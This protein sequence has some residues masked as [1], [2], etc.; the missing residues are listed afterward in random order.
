MSK[1]TPKEIIRN[2]YLSVLGYE[3]K[4]VFAKTI[5][6]EYVFFINLAN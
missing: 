4:H 5:F 6:T 1:F 2:R 3:N